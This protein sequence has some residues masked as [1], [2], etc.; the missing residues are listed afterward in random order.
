M[1]CYSYTF[2]RIET[3]K[4]LTIVAILCQVAGLENSPPAPHTRLGLGMGLE[5]EEA[6]RR[7]R[8][9]GRRGI[10]AATA[11]TGVS[12]GLS[13]IRPGNYVLSIN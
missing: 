4:K 10:M 1:G 2:P 7:E 8:T 5:L 13:L 3:K 12:Q 11:V 6:R 9:G